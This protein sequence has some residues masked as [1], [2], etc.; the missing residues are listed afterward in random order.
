MGKCND[1]S[2]T[3]QPSICLVKG[4]KTQKSIGVTESVL[5]DNS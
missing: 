2:E 3:E 4:N 5:Y 1:R